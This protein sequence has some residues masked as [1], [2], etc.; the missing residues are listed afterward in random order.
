MIYLDNAASTKISTAALKAMNEAYDSFGNPSSG[1]E[2]GMAA[3]KLLEDARQT[4][5]TA[6]GCKSENI[7]FTSG[8]TEADN[9]AIRS[10]AETGKLRGKTHIISS[11]TEHHAV[12]HTLSYLELNGYDVTYLDVDSEGLVSPSDVRAAIRPD[13]CLVTIMLVNNETGAKQPIQEIGQICKEAGVPLHTDAVQAVGHIHVDVEE[14]G[15]DYLSA[16]AH[17]F[18]G[19]QGVGFLY[20]RDPHQAVPIMYGGGQEQGLRPGTENVPGIVGMAVALAEFHDNEEYHCRHLQVLRREL[21]KLLLS[22]PGVTINSPKSEADR[23]PGI[24][25]ISVADVP[26]YLLVQALSSEGVCVST[27]SACTTG[28]PVPSHVLTAMGIPRQEAETAIRISLSRDNGSDEISRADESLTIKIM[29][30]R[31]MI[32]QVTS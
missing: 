10:A 11:K 28:D 18:H 20:V 4:I 25:N 32:H 2:A 13:T 17:K 22:I 26:G 29:Q 15:V 27:G 12:L 9:L 24:L 14:L 8:G 16:S 5:A 21:E 19:P 6:I 7:I 3:L 31:R 30:I 1:H 23:V